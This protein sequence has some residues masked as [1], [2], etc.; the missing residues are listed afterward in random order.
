MLI[1]EVAE[2]YTLQHRASFDDDAA[3]SSGLAAGHTAGNTN[4]TVL[5]IVHSADMSDGSY[6]HSFERERTLPRQGFRVA[7]S[8]SPGQSLIMPAIN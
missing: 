7:L 6:A 3:N 8:M 1:P 4:D 2:K 5:A